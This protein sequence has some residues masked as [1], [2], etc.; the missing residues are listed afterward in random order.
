MRQAQE[1][2][3]RNTSR[4]QERERRGQGKGGAAQRRSPIST[5]VATPLLTTG[6]LDSSASQPTK[7]GILELQV[8]PRR[9]K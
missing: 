4:G 3:V 1:A 8:G 6:R 7:F 9:K 2:G 5:G